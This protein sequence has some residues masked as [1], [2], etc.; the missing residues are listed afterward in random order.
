VN[1]SSSHY[2]SQAE[3]EN[4]I[5]KFDDDNADV[6]PVMQRLFREGSVMKKAGLGNMKMGE[7]K[8]SSKL[9]KELFLKIVVLQLLLLAL[10]L[11]ECGESMFQ[12]K[13]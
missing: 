12:E 10:H 4:F 9:K 3:F 5:D 2:Y 8:R 1:N 6:Y 7:L 13:K 11:G